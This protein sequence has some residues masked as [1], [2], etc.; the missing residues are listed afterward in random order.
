MACDRQNDEVRKHLDVHHE[1]VLSLIK[2]T[3]DNAHKN[4]IT[5]GV[6]GGLAQDLDLLDFFIENK[7]DELSVGQAQ[8]LRLK[9]SICLK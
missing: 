3:I 2:M 1:A 4:G 8:I 7:V 9:H 6:C 5:V